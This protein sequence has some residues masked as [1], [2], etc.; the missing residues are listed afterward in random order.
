[1]ERSMIPI[2]VGNDVLTLRN[3]GFDF[4]TEKLMGLNWVLARVQ[5]ELELHFFMPKMIY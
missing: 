3:D 4:L 5:I 1:M 2:F